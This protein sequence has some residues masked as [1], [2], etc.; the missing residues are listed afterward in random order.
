MSSYS[1][2]Q[3]KENL[4]GEA[5]KNQ[6]DASGRLLTSGHRERIAAR[7][8]SLTLAEMEA[9]RKL[10]REELS[11][12]KSVTGGGLSVLEHLSC[13][14]FTESMFERILNVMVVVREHHAAQRGSD[15]LV[16]LEQKYGWLHAIGEHDELLL[17][18]ERNYEDVEKLA[19]HDLVR[20]GELTKGV[21][22]GSKGR[23]GRLRSAQRAVLAALLTDSVKYGWNRSFGGNF[24]QHHLDGAV[25]AELVLQRFVGSDFGQGDINQ[26]IHSILEH[27]ISP[28]F[29]MGSAY[30]G[31]VE[32]WYPQDRSA[33]K[34]ALSGDQLAAAIKEI[35][36]AIENPLSPDGD[37]EKD[38]RG[39][40]KLALTPIARTLLERYA[41]EGCSNWYVLHP[42]TPWY[43]ASC[44]TVAADCFDNYFC[45]FECGDLVKGPFKIAAARGPYVGDLHIDQAIKSIRDSAQSSLSLLSAADLKR[46]QYRLGDDYVIYGTACA[47]TEG[48]LRRKLGLRSYEELPVIPYWNEKLLPP[49]VNLSIWRE[50]AE[51]RFAQEIQQ[52]FATELL[53]MRL[54]DGKVPT[55]IEPVRGTVN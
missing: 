44:R 3:P 30:S 47:R 14:G 43:Y 29:F 13:F 6:M 28:P 48:W 33:D 18:I 7:F 24:F 50:R 4:A 38:E 53:A 45:S 10:V 23:M 26:I 8:Q 49:D 15:R 37:Y 35:R 52:R 19:G 11:N 55:D 16:L 54:F 25:A 46:A 39:G 42:A 1:S 40:Y 41:G 20:F 31:E 17:S 5:L 2:D 9:G 32:R 34:P 27:Q 36:H 12:Y 51:V 22:F 21:A